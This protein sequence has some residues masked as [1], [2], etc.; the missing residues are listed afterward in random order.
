MSNV[1]AGNKCNDCKIYRSWI[2]SEYDADVPCD[3]YDYMDDDY[4]NQWCFIEEYE[5]FD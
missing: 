5:V 1:Y 2:D 4:S 3:E